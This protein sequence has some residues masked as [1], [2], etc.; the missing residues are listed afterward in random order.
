MLLEIPAFY[1]RMRVKN[2]G[3]TQAEKVQII[4]EQLYRKDKKSGKFEKDK[5]FLPMRVKWTH[6]ESGEPVVITDLNP[7]MGRHCDIGYIEEPRR[8]LEAPLPGVSAGETL[9]SLELEKKPNTRSHLLIPGDYL[10]ELIISPANANPIKKVLAIKLT[11]DWR[12]TEEEMFRDG[13]VIKEV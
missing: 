7:K 6:W 3:K 4:A 13:I 2:K 11:G 9:L 8:R 10:L 5:T 1:F 12:D